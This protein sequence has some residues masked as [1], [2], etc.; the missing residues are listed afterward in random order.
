MANFIKS[1]CLSAKMK[2]PFDTFG[3]H[4]SGF[5]KIVDECTMCSHQLITKTQT[6]SQERRNE[7]WLFT[8]CRCKLSVVQKD[9]QQSLQLLI[10][11]A[12]NYMMNVQ[13][14]KSFML[15]M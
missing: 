9:N 13:T 5:I 1:V 14:S 12:K 11:V 3:V 2:P 15:V 7:S 8:I 10:E 6:H 4:N